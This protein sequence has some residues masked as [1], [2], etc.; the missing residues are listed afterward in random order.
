MNLFL[1][2][3][4]AIGILG[5]LGLVFGGLL[6]FAATKFRVD[7]D[8]LIEQVTAL[9]PGANC[10][11]CGYPGC[12]GLACAMV[13]QGVSLSTCPVMKEENRKRIGE[14]LGRDAGSAVAKVAFVRCGGLPGE[15]YEKFEYKG[16]SGCQAAVLI[17]HGNKLCPHRC[18]GM[19]SCEKACPFGAITMGDDELPIIDDDKC[20]ACGKCVPA[21][22]KGLILLTDKT[23]RTRVR[24]NSPEK[25]ADVRKVCKVGC[26]GC[27]LCEKACKYGAVIIENNL[28]RIDP[29]KCVE[30]GACV[31]KCPQKTIVL[32]T[33]PP[34]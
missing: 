32:G 24:C 12:S 28:A 29:E 10:G 34:A 16:I 30:C 6:A 17:A 19:G 3:A 7:I 18:L 11:G 26:I 31:A 9:L 4:Q 23:K 22:P 1:P 27:R 2:F 8:P 14:L 25:G 5:G 15:E 33:N 20:T 13:Q 21:C